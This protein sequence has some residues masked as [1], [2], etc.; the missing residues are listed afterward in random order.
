MSPSWAE[1]TI[2]NIHTVHATI[3]HGVAYSMD[4]MDWSFMG[5]LSASPSAS[6]VLRRDFSALKSPT[7][8]G[9]ARKP[10]HRLAS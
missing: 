8:A 6:K 2:Q 4:T 9:F 3:S 5:T 7:A 1:P 10:P